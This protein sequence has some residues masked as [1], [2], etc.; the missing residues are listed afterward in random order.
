[1]AALRPSGS[2][3]RTIQIFA[4]IFHLTSRCDPALTVLVVERERLGRA[5]QEAS[6]ATA[7]V[8]T[9]SDWWALD[10]TVRREV[11][12]RTR[13]VPAFGL[14]QVRHDVPEIRF[15]G[16]ERDCLHSVTGTSPLIDIEGA[17]KI[18]LLTANALSLAPHL[19]EVGLPE[20]AGPA[21]EFCGG[22]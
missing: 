7:P 19:T 20:S 16:K 4:C 8:P 9:G 18:V 1:K 3:T 12:R 6:R 10:A 2:L 17:Q 22:I 15:G 5:D 14:G 11:V 21:E 13:L